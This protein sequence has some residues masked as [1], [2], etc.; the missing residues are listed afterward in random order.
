MGLDRSWLLRLGS[1]VRYLPIENKGTLVWLGLMLL[2]ALPLFLTRV[3]HIP[4]LGVE[5]GTPA[6]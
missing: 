1:M 3:L 6:H 2:L 5:F 4:A